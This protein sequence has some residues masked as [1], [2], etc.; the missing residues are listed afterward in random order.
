MPGVNTL[1]FVWLNLFVVGAGGNEVKPEPKS[2]PEY[3]EQDDDE[4]EGLEYLNVS[5]VYDEGDEFLLDERSESF[6]H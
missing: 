6:F 1:I 5:K 2:S 4:E 3:S